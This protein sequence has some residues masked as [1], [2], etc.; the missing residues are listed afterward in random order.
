M[1]DWLVQCE[2]FGASL[3][4]HNSLPNPRLC[5]K[6][7]RADVSTKHVPHYKFFLQAENKAK[8]ISKLQR[9]SSRESVIQQ[10]VH[11]PGSRLSELASERASEREDDRSGGGGAGRVL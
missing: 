2:L 3:K 11:E 5:E 7:S 4:Q 10:Q 6:Y 9:Q 8:S 1:P